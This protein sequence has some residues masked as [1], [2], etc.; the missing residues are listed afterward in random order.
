[1]SDKSCSDL[2]EYVRKKLASK[3]EVLEVLVELNN[4]LSEDAEL[5]LRILQE[6]D[7]E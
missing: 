6:D 7:Q 2:D 4:A 1:M 5:A 3:Q